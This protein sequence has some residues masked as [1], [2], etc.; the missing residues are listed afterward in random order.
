LD[1]YVYELCFT[2]D[3][4]DTDHRIHSINDILVSQYNHY[5]YINGR[6][7]VHFFVQLFCGIIG[8]DIFN[9]CNT[10]FLFVFTYL[11]FK[12][13][14]IKY[15]L[16]SLCAII[17]LILLLPAWNNVFLWMTGS[18]NYLWSISWLLIYLYVLK[19]NK[20]RN[21]SFKSSKPFFFFLFG[22]FA[23]WQHEG[24]TIPLAFGLLIYI[25]TEHR[26]S[27]SSPNLYLVIGFFL[28]ALLCCISPGTLGRAGSSSKSLFD[29]IYQIQSS[30]LFM[31]HLRLF[32]LYLAL[33]FYLYYVIKF[34]VFQYIKDERVL[35][36]ALAFSFLIFTLMQHSARASFGIE[37]YSLLLII[38]IVNKAR[39]PKASANCLRDF[40]KKDK[41]EIQLYAKMAYV[42]L[43]CFIFT[44][45]FYSF[46]NFRNSQVMIDQLEDS[47]MD[48][49]WVKESS[50]P[51]IFSKYIQKPIKEFDNLEAIDSKSW[52]NVLIAAKY[53][54]KQVSFLPESLR[55]ILEKSNSNE[56][57]AFSIPSSTSIHIREIDPSIQ[58]VSLIYHFH[59]SNMI[60]L[61][62]C[63][64]R[65]MIKSDYFIIENF[66]GKRFILTPLLD[67]Y[68]EK[69]LKYINIVLKDGSII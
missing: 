56:L 54:H 4:V 38:N 24:L 11:L 69:R 36:C 32:Y 57:S 41:E 46:A 63:K 7:I 49:I 51:F 60:D 9:I 18:I 21:V 10:L 68:R 1:D 55:T 2:G 64:N 61:L 59:K 37:F 20:D 42:L 67:R 53:N 65:E 5:L 13:F 15:N 50:A 30:L 43:L 58:P 45:T 52:I 39:S 26:A 23:G 44:I 28:G 12:V 48:I 17:F 35:L 3:G 31:V 25:I 6:A 8:K 62:H 34:N 66:Y 22:F 47:R 40:F 29:Y 33:F 27:F 16:I 19:Q 14:D